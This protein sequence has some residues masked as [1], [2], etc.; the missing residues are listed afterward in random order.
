MKT[1]LLFL[2]LLVTVNYAQTLKVSGKI[3][4]AQTREPL[5]F[6]NVYSEETNNGTISDVFGNYE[7]SLSPGKYNLLVSYLGYKSENRPLELFTE[8]VEL[9]VNLISTG[10]L[11]QEVS[12][13][14]T[15]EDENSTSSISLQSKE[16]EEISSIL[17]D[18]FRSIQALP[19]VAVNNEFSAKF[20]VRGGNYDEN[21]VL[22]NGTQV[23]E[24]F[25][26][27][28]ADNASIGIFNIDLMKSVNIITGG[29]SAQY[30]DRLSSVLN[31]KYREGNKDRYSGSTTLSLTNL[32][33][34][35][36]GPLGSK[37]SFLLGMR[38]SY[39]EY[40]L[41]LIEVEESAKPS[42]YDIQGVLTYNFGELNK[43]QIKF[44]HAGDDFERIPGLDIDGPYNWSGTIFNEQANFQE[45][46]EYLQETTAEY[47]SN[48]LDLQHQ[49]FFT[50]NARLITSLSYYNQIDRVF[51]S[52]IGDY[53]FEADAQNFYFFKSVYNELTEYD[54]SIKTFEAKTDLEF[55]V[56]PYYDIKSGISYL[57][58]N[59]NQYLLDQRYWVVDQNIDSFPDTLNYIT[60]ESEH[61]TP[62]IIKTNSFKYAVYTENILQFGNNILLNVG[63]RFDYFDINKD[64]TI[65]PR[66]NL[67]YQL[68]EETVLRLAWGHYYQSPIYRQLAYSTPSDT[69]TQSQKAEHYIVSAERK[70]PFNGG[71]STFTLKLEGYYKKYSDLISSEREFGGDVNY[72]RKNDSEG[73]AAGFDLYTTLRIP[74]YYAWISYSLL[75]SKEDLLNDNLGEFPRYTDQRH[76]I[77]VVNDIDLG[78]KWNMNLRFTYGSGF[79]YTP[80]VKVFNPEIG[81]EQWESGSKNSAHLPEYK[82]IDIRFGKEFTIWGLHTLAF[83]DVNNLLNFKNVYALRYTYNNSGNPYIDELE[84]WPILP[85]LG[86]TVKF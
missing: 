70:F 29:F 84:L 63:V 50:N 25:H 75:F 4:D 10:I 20:N 60:D 86:I 26:I 38:K 74:D 23:Y 19:G 3:R 13:Y 79:A 57:N 36:E 33:A 37:G 40:V 52:G 35:V 11:L 81:R 21:L 34:L 78:K 59:Y 54:L 77:S 65:S 27:K 55:R 22:V 49:V 80:S 24:P 28:E 53:I 39:L 61:F 14:A 17:P 58:I 12:V 82:R 8:N 66:L 30:G 46:Y 68:D 67:S 18:V 15:E 73:Y 44:I 56:N 47:F 69:N 51:N 42:F 1:K 62:E 43:L 32:D 31:I 9:N 5:A 6:A 7:F 71:N 41:S 72:S 2:I 45:G 83:I 64:L 85:T 48:L 76:T 16:M